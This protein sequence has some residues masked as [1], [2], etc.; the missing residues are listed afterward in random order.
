[1]TLSTLGLPSDLVRMSLTPAAS[2]TARTPP[3]AITPVPGEAGLRNTSAPPCSATISC[4]IVVPLKCTGFIFLRAR[5]VP[6]R[7]ASGTARLLPTPTPTRPL[8]SPTTTT[9]RNAKRRPP[10]ITFATR[11]MSTTRSSSSSRSSPALAALSRSL[12]RGCLCFIVVLPLLEFQAGVAGGIGQRLHPPLIAVP[13]T[14][15]YHGF[16]ALGQRPLGHCHANDLRLLD[17]L[18]AVEL[19]FQF[20]VNARCLNQR[21]AGLTVT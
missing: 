17:L 2:S 21:V 9:V 1:M 12:T 8:L 14:V 19:G 4:G 20:R 13:G 18:L 7:I 3:A 5:S 11:E 15:E 6:L 10:L 16:D